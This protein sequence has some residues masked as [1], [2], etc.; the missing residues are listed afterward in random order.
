MPASHCSE[1]GGTGSSGATGE[2]VHTRDQPC[3]EAVFAIPQPPPRSQPL[4][5]LFAPFSYPNDESPE[6]CSA[7]LPHS[8]IP[9]SPPPTHRTGKSTLLRNLASRQ[10]G[11]I[12]AALTIHYVSQEVKLDDKAME[13]TP[14]QVRFWCTAVVDAPICADSIP[15]L[16]I[17]WPPCEPSNGADTAAGA[18]TQSRVWDKAVGSRLSGTLH[19][20]LAP[21]SGFHIAR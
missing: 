14:L 2:A 10:V 15:G 18:T 6:A 21:L 11:D 16:H 5:T 19:H 4:H 3:P 13:L 17:P 20:T 8:F 9:T 1:E 7:G 12:P